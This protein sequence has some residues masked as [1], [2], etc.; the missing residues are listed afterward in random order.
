M[1]TFGKFLQ[2]RGMLFI[3]IKIKNGLRKLLTETKSK[4]ENETV[5][6]M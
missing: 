4:V 3:C 6:K 2:S 5:G 1:T